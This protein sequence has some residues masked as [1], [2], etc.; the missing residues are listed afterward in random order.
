MLLRNSVSA[1]D[2]IFTKGKGTKTFNAYLVPRKPCQIMDTRQNLDHLIQENGF[3]EYV[4]IHP[5]EIR[6]A[7]WVRIK[8][9]YGCDDYGRACC[10]PNVPEISSC[11][12]FF[13]E[14]T[15]AVVLG[16]HFEAEK[17]NY[18]KQLSR[19]ID[20]RLVELERQ[21]FLA[22]YY[23]AFVFTQSCCSLCT[24]CAA[25]R[26]DCHFPE[27]SRPSA[28]AFGVDVYA[29]VRE[30]GLPINVVSTPK[31]HIDR[32]AFLMVE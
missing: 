29:T 7:Q 23:K 9:L 26:A 3:N 22:G 12:E 4:W 2:L 25:S 18:P 14:Y 20:Q 11:R 21:V 30:Q 27:K 17:G 1:E 10:P 16:F 31:Q 32:Y 13:G 19:Q 28:E 6:V 5:R 24:E 8:C 15:R